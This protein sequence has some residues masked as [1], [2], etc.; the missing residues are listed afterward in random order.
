[1]P[2][3]RNELVR[4]AFAPLMER[5]FSEPEWW[6]AGTDQMV[7]FRR[8]GVDVH[9][10]SEDMGTNLP[11]AYIR[12]PDGSLFYLVDDSEYPAFAKRFLVWIPW[13][14]R[15][16]MKAEIQHEFDTR[17]WRLAALVEAHVAKLA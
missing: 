13:Y 12:Q 2:R 10:E 16:R 6:L 5:G 9:L 7:T 4:E 14:G 3:L 1:M 15:G 11:N 8:D 17:V